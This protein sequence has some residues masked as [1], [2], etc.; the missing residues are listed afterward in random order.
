MRGW[1]TILPLLLQMIILLLRMLLLTSLLTYLLTYLLTPWSRVNL[2]KLTI[3]ANQEIS[4][5]LWNLKVHYRIHKC[6]SPVPILCQLDPVHTTHIPLPKDPTYY[7]PI[8]AWV[9]QVV[10]F[11]QVSQP[12]PCIRLSP[13]PY[14]LLLLT[15]ILR[16]CRTRKVNATDTTTTTTTT[17][18]TNTTTT[19]KQ[20]LP[21][22]LLLLIL[23]YAHYR[24]DLGLQTCCAL[25][26]NWLIL[27]L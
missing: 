3:S 5:I 11:P 13:H 14:A 16:K 7:P 8:Y 24:Q 1:G 9:S 15:I 20:L 18:T 17:T 26:M 10:S 23:K 2:E 12:E 19:T 21:L 22:L 6:P 25:P 4:C 27:P